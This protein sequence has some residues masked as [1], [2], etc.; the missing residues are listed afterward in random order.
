VTEV[1][2]EGGDIEGPCVFTLRQ[3]EQK[4]AEIAGSGPNGFT[5]I[6]KRK[7]IDRALPRLAVAAYLTEAF[8]YDRIELTAR[9]LESGLV[10]ETWLR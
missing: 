8:G 3:L 1:L 5:A 9:E 7:D 6:K 10:I 2:F 4:L